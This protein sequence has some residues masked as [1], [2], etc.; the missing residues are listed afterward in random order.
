VRELEHEQELVEERRRTRERI[1]S[2]LHDDVASTLSSVA[3]FAESLK[4]RIGEASAEIRTLL[5]KISTLSLEAEDAVGDIVWS[6]APQHDSLQELCVR[7]RDVGSDLCTS[8]GIEF[9]AEFTPPDQELL[10]DDA[11]RKNLYL[12]FKEGIQNV[13]KHSRARSVRL[14]VSVQEKNLYFSLTDDGNGFAPPGGA[15]QR[16]RGHGLRN[17]AR[18]AQSVGASFRID[19]SLG[20]G[21]VLELTVPLT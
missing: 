5:Q 9:R 2:D 6:V 21:T 8:H 1:A 17:M 12:I 15:M 10:L 16:D 19:S 14:A 13:M 3:F 11:V 7:M 18:R 20:K 4:Q